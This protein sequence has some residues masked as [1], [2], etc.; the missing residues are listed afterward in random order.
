MENWNV[1]EIRTSAI[2]EVSELVAEKSKAKK[3]S[4]AKI[5]MNTSIMI[6]GLFIFALYLINSS[7]SAPSASTESMGEGGQVPAT[8]PTA[9]PAPAPVVAQPAPTPAPAPIVATPTA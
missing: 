4:T 2:R 7:E 6:V 5:P 1:D 3:P 8:A 9:T